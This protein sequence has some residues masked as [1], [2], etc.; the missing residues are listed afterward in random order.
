MVQASYDKYKS[1]AQDRWQ[2]KN[3]FEKIQNVLDRTYS[4]ISLANNTENVWQM[5]W[6]KLQ[7]ACDKMHYFERKIQK[8]TQYTAGLVNDLVSKYESANKMYLTERVSKNVFDN[9]FDRTNG[10]LLINYKKG[11]KLGIV[12]DCK[13]KYKMEIVIN[14]KNKYKMEID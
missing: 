6:Q 13:K 5:V 8:R 11:F 3:I 12:I 4:T 9:R 7:N 1:K 2:I 10:N 14:Y